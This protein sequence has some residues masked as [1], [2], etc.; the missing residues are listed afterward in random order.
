VPFAHGSD[1]GG[2]VRIPSSFC[3]LYGFKPSLSLLGNMHG[4][5]NKTGLS[6]M[7][8]LSHHVE[9]AAA[10]LDVLAGRYQHRRF[11]SDSCLAQSRRT[12]RRLRIRFSSKSPIGRVEPNIARAVEDTAGELASLGH[13]VEPVDM[14][15]ASLEDFLPIWQFQL[16]MVPVWSDRPLQPITRWLREAGRSL[17]LSHVLELREHLASRIDDMLGDAD[18]MLTAT[19]PVPA[20]RVGAFAGL[21]PAAQFE[22]VSDI[23]ALTA[24]YNVSLSPAASLP[25]GLTDAGLPIGVQI[26][27]RPGQDY[28]ILSLSRQLEEVMDWH[29]RRTSFFE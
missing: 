24:G 23:G 2:S 9:D 14:I 3:H 19:T 20:P 6:T 25:A 26:A 27:G 10:M 21:D 7:G 28:L 29:R 11:G 17:S 12:P 16:A 18:I 15:D 5:V 8:P 1:G 4:R 13:D 22:A